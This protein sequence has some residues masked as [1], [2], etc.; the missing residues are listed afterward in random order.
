MRG[1]G[2]K[3]P[4]DPKKPPAK[5]T[6]SWIDF[7]IETFEY[8]S[9]ENSKFAYRR[10]RKKQ[11]KQNEDDGYDRRAFI[12]DDTIQWLD[13]P[14][15]KGSG[16][17]FYVDSTRYLPNSVTISKILVRVVDSNIRDV[18]PPSTRVAE[19]K[20]DI[21][22]PVFNFR[23]ELRLPF[24]NPTLMVIITLLTVD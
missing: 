8:E 1:S 22:K 23:L 24:F 13:V 15:E 17:D 16:V 21:Y 12:P 4:P 11:K 18:V 14:F 2:R 7:T 20:S 10:K 19:F 6:K 9:M 5:R 3:P